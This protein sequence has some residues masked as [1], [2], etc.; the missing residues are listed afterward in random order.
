[1]SRFFTDRLSALT[2][3]VPGEQPKDRTYVKL[4]TNESPYPPT[5]AVAAA[6]REETAN[7]R[8]YPDP[9]NGDLCRALARRYGVGPENVTVTN[10]SDEALNFAFLAF[11]DENAP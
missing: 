9:Q 4:N 2:P 1:M 5:E 6:A 7:S 10:G 8:L 11:A 3:Y